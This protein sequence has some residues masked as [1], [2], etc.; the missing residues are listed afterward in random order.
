MEQQGQ[1]I[2]Q[3]GLKYTASPCNTIWWNL[4]TRRYTST[5]SS[6]MKACWRILVL[7]WCAVTGRSPNDRFVIREPSS[8]DSVV[9]QGESTFCDQAL[10]RPPGR[11]TAICRASLYVRTVTSGPTHIRLPSASSTA[12]QS[13][14]AQHVSQES[15]RETCQHQ[16]QFTVIDAPG[17]NASPEDD[18]TRSEA[19]ILL[20]FGRRE[21]IVGGTAYAG[22]MKKSMFTV[23]NYLLPPQGVLSM[24]CSANYGKNEND[25][26]IFFGLSGTGKT[27]LSA[28]PQRTL[29]GDDEH[30]WSDQGV[31][32]F[33]GGCYAK[34]K[35]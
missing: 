8:Q 32:N 25:V 1:V 3:Q 5:P 29:I 19:F 33:E 2:S 15:I 10:R 35:L 31:F 28:D 12:Q 4:S 26:A 18:G 24:H 21:V 16:P 27:T 7:W 20:H 14:C 11:L 22:E 23:M 30:G 9:G 34:V 17:F 13:F 6:G